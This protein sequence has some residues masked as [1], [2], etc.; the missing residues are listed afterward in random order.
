MQE[1]EKVWDEIGRP[2][3][4]SRATPLKEVVEFLKNKKGK[5]LDLGCGSGRNFVESK[6]LE[7]YGVDFSQKMIDLAK[8]KN[9]K[10]LIKANAW[11][12]PFKDSFFDA[13]LYIAS[14]HCI[15]NEENREKSLQ[16]LKRVMKPG[17]RALIT[18]WDK[19]QEKFKDAGKETY[20]P[21]IVNVEGKEKKAMRYYYLYEKEELIDLLSKYFKVVKVYKK[22]EH[23]DKISRRFSKRNLII[24]IEKS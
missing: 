19:N 22:I 1:Q 9:Y 2:W 18:V 3:K 4:E 10:Q 15:P 16:E 5:I 8:E 20:I 21:W 13:A 24:E 12:L 7:F 23:E 14:L 6:E 17:A 11:Q